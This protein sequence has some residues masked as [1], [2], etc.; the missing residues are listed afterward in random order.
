MEIPVKKKS[1]IYIMSFV[2][3][4][5]LI[6]AWVYAVLSASYIVKSSVKFILFLI[7]PFSYSMIDR[8]V[9]FRRL[10]TFDKKGMCFSLILGIC[11]YLFILAA[12]FYLG[13]FFDLSNITNALQKNI[14]INSENFIFVTLYI[15][16]I[17]S[18]LEEFFFRGFAFLCLIKTAGRKTAYLFSA[19]VFALYHVTIMK[20]WF[21]SVLLF[22]LIIASLFIGG[23][24]FNRLNEKNGNIYSSW[25]VHMCANLAINTVGFILFGIL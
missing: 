13:P 3:A 8:E 11:V 7:L 1:T 10:F 24:L 6:M 17:N 14:G 25:F 16:I 5:C 12:Y 20:G 22:I 21:G 19:G 23:L 15:C 2:I 9:S 4:G 18:L